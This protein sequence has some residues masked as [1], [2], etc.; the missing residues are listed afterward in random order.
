MKLPIRSLLLVLVL[1]ISLYALALT[2]SGDVPLKAIGTA[3]WSPVGAVAAV[4]CLCN[5]ALRGWRWRCWMDHLGRPLPA[6]TALRLYLC[7]YAFTA[8]PGNV[9]EA[10]RGWLLKPPLSPAQSV[11][12]FGAE[13][14]ADLLGLLLLSLPAVLWLATDLGYPLWVA[15]VVLTIASALA[16]VVLQRLGQVVGGSTPPGG[17]PSMAAAVPASKA[18]AITSKARTLT[19]TTLA[20][21]GKAL[22]AL[23]QAGACL[24]HQP[25]H[26]LALTVLAWAAQGVAVWLVC[27]QH[28]VTLPVWLA[29]GLYAL[30]MVGGALSMLPAGLGGTEAILSGLLLWAAPETLALAQAVLITLVVRLLTLWLAVGLGLLTLLYSAYRRL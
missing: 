25:L 13:R 19:H 5:Y 17:A 21:A 11:S 30:S 4:L 16:W 7:G 24:R 8:T 2:L 22:Q 12:M 10:A 20:L 14:V 18:A 6:A 9:G 26:W 23:Q 1:A 27:V 15:V 3:L 29:S 28:G